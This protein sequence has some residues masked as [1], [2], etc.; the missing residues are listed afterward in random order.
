MR[1]DLNPKENTHILA[2]NYIGYLAYMYHERPF[3]VPITYFY[4][5]EN[6]T[7]ICY[8]NEGHKLTAMRQNHHVSLCVAD[9]DSVNDW[10]SVVAYGTFR[11]LVGSEAKTQLHTFTLGVKDLIINKEL[12][13]LDYIQQFS[14]KF[15][16]DDLP[17]VFV[18]NVSEIT[19]KLRRS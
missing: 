2:N 1:R 6:N 11:E 10:E 12:R 4:D 17:A 3:I 13:K 5:Q 7:I 14:A 18:I 16:A 8:S 9:I 15:K 19:G